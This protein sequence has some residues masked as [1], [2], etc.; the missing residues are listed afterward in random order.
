MEGL[1]IVQLEEDHSKDMG[2][3][4]L[5]DVLAV[6]NTPAI[7]PSEAQKIPQLGFIIRAIDHTAIGDFGNQFE[8]TG[9]L[10]LFC[11]SSNLG[12]IQERVRRVSDSLELEAVHVLDRSLE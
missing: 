12:N 6:L 8:E 11:D 3:K 4:W 9:N 2:R 5:E 10:E 7:E 1:R